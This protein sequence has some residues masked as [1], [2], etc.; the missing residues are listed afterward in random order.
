M[1]DAVRDDM[2]SECLLATMQNN[3]SQ[4]SQ[5]SVKTETSKKESIRSF[6][7]SSSGVASSDS[8]DS[9]KRKQQYDSSYARNVSG[10]VRVTLPSNAQYVEYETIQNR[11]FMEEPFDFNN[12]GFTYGS[13]GSEGSVVDSPQTIMENNHKRRKLSNTARRSNDD[14]DDDQVEEDDDE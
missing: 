14:S 13:R 6:G 12:R 9:R 7:D 5:S 11:N 2:E 10:D 3:N 1:A 4:S 8:S